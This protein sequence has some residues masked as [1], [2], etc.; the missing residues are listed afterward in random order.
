[1]ATII[2]E[3]QVEEMELQEGETFANIEE[4]TPVQEIGEEPPV[5]EE[6]VTEDTPDTALAKA[7]IPGCPTSK[8]QKNITGISMPLISLSDTVS[9]ATSIAVGFFFN[10]AA[11]LMDGA[12]T[13]DASV[14]DNQ[15]AA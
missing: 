12:P 7:P 9:P 13:I 6:S 1:M 3:E 2:D 4:D 10:S 11:C 14:L 8:S 5:E 15:L